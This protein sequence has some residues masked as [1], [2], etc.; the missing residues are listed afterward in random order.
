MLSVLEPQAFPPFSF[1]VPEND[2]C[3]HNN[4]QNHRGPL[5]LSPAASH[6]HTWLPTVLLFFESFPLFSSDSAVFVGNSVSLKQG[7]IFHYSTA[8]QKEEMI[9]SKELRHCLCSFLQVTNDNCVRLITESRCSR[10]GTV[11]LG[12][13][14]R[15][16]HLSAW[17]QGS[18]WKCAWHVMSDLRRK[19]QCVCVTSMLLNSSQTVITALHHRQLYC[20]TIVAWYTS[21]N[22]ICV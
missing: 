16:V 4:E 19:T 21:L 1:L 2:S 9:G 7:R 22:P 17:P 12:E 8:G 14:V 20:H 5:G 11:H 15:R 10:C 3:V 13:K 6:Y 18:G